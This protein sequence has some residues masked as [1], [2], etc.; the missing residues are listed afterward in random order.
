MGQHDTSQSSKSDTARLRF[1]RA[2]LD[3]LEVLDRMCRSGMIE[4]GNHRIGAEQEM[5]LVDGAR[6]PAPVALEVLSVLNSP[7]FT[8]ELARFN[9]EFNTVPIHFGSGSLTALEIELGQALERVRLAAR[10]F[11][12]TVLLAGIL[13]AIEATDLTLGNLTPL[14]RYLELNRLVTELVAGRVRTFIKGQDELQL[15]HANVMLESCNTSFQIHLQVDVEDFPRLYNLAQVITAPVLAAAVNS[16]LLL[17]QRLWHETR[18][19]LFEQSIDIRSAP[20]RSRRS[21]QRVSFGEGW[22]NHSVTELFREQIARH[23]VMFACDPGESSTAILDRGEIPELPALRMHNGSVYCWNRACYG[24]MDGKPHLRIEHRPLPAGP[25]VLDEVANAAFFYG[26][27]SAPMNRFG[28]VRT[29]FTF[30]DAKANFLA[31]ARHGLEATFRWA[32]RESIGAR[33]LILERLL[34]LAAEGLLARGVSEAESAHY[35]GVIEGRVRTG[36]TGAAWTLAAFER[37]TEGNRTVR[38]QA[39]TRALAE[40]Q[41]SGA[42]VHTWSLPDP[43]DQGLWFDR[44]RYVAQ[45]MTSDLFT[46]RPDSLVDVG[47]SVMRWKHLRHLP[48]QNDQGELVGLVS[49]QSLIRLMATPDRHPGPF[50]VSELMTPNPISVPPDLPTLDAVALMRERQVACL[51]VVYENRLVGIV[52]ERDLLPIVSRSMS[53]VAAQAGSVAELMTHV[54]F[55]VEPTD[56]VTTVA[57]LM[58]RRHFRHVPV[59]ADERLIGLVSYRSLLAVLAAGG[60]ER[61]LSA[62]D[63]MSR[64][65][66]TVSSAATPLEAVALML[67]RRVSCLPVVDQGRL[68]GI[69][70]ERDFLPLADRQP[71]REEPLDSAGPVKVSPSIA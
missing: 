22:V 63:I 31:A 69:L 44:Y 67:E 35:L 46:V 33:E 71:G 53:R 55:T 49:Y 48:V 5:F 45:V 13:P 62:G 6:R 32:G 9:L 38:A 43:E 14:P 65:P 68:V 34:P 3:D 56:S 11:N 26:L 4:R 59:V 17:Q 15:E 50:A 41:W 36:Q 39:V 1:A 61:S 30:E 37:L 60:L 42:P 20:D 10:K 51:P 27:M 2:M 29:A 70:S 7:K 21:W 16:P 24:V 52:S 64:D 47:A 58:S 28:D 57:S 18:I 66:A 8:T 54:V 23:R 40:R 19:A 12:A 25:T